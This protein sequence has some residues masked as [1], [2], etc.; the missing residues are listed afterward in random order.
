M[1]PETDIEAAQ[2]TIPMVASQRWA[3][4]AGNECLRARP[5]RPGVRK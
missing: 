1:I 5:R 4:I 2:R 3:L